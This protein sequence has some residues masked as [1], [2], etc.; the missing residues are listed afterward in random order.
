LFTRE[1][2]MGSTGQQRMKEILDAAINAEQAAFD[3]YDRALG[4]VEGEQA[5]AVLKE[6]RDDELLHKE[7]LESAAFDAWEALPRESG[8]DEITISEFLV[9]GDLSE[10]ADF[11]TVI[12]FAAKKE[13]QAK[14]FYSGAAGIAAGTAEKEFFLKLARMEEL[15]EKKCEAL[16]WET[17]GG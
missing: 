3:L 17:Y 16:Y 9:G 7:M 5:K 12:L 8:E 14:E 10:D 6:L 15:H 11:Q 1:E 2:H 4:L 13:R